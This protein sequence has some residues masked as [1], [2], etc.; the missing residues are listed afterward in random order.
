MP[1]LKIS[2]DAF[3]KPLHKTTFLY[4]FF[5]QYFINLEI[6]SSVLGMKNLSL[7]YF[8]EKK[9]L[10]LC[11]NSAYKLV[12]CILKCAQPS[13]SFISSVMI[14]QQIMSIGTDKTIST[15][16][17]QE[18]ILCTPSAAMLFELCCAKDLFVWVF[19]LV[20]IFEFPLFFENWTVAFV[21]LK[22]F[23]KS[24]GK[25]VNFFHLLTDSLILHFS[26]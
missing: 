17:K 6:V 23:L 16:F 12:P 3:L 1:F 25:E 26:S 4:F 13:F 14:Y 2:S 8:S 9:V 7:P 22:Y 10:L 24:G 5:H 18:L 21:S 20:I 19:S 11:S 15:S